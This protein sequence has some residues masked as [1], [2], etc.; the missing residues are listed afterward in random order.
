MYHI[1]TQRYEYAA[2]YSQLAAQCV[3]PYFSPEWLDAVCGK[4]GWRCICIVADNRQV[5]LFPYYCPVPS[6]ITQ[7]PFTQFLG[8]LIATTSEAKVSFSDQRNLVEALLEHFPLVSSCSL[9]TSPQLTDWLPF[10][11]RGFRQTTRYT[12]ILELHQNEDQSSLP[13]KFN[14]LL[15]RK[16]RTAE[17]MGLSFEEECCFSDLKVM[18]E[19]SLGRSHTHLLYADRLE[20]LYQTMHERQ[21][22]SIY[23]STLNGH[24]V[25]SV[26]MVRNAHCSYYI[27]G[28]QDES[29]CKDALAH[30]LYNA[31]CTEIEKYGS[32]SIDFEGSMIRGVEF[33]FRSFGAIQTPYFALSRGKMSI[34]SRICRKLLTRP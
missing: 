3:A 19:H 1:S 20:Q 18:V 2:I 15:R 4:E 32:R 14:Q 25:A 29:Q 7:P 5:L 9:H 26:F 30:C 16:L 33:F 17:R 8:P 21:R 28:G 10:H 22:G 24:T 27:A 6:A 34:L 31:I 13:G 23:K 11:W 12:Y